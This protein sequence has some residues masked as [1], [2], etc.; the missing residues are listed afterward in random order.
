MAPLS[1]QSVAPSSPSLAS[2]SCIASN[3]STPTD[4]LTFD[5]EWSNKARAGEATPFEKSRFNY[6][7]VDWGRLPGFSIPI[8]QLTGKLSSGIWKVGVPT[9]DS[10]SSN[11][12]WLCLR[13]HNA[14]G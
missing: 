8:T 9:E 2:T 14:E 5:S 3:I 4:E 12:W 13:C 6:D 11:R 7:S 1:T 10:K